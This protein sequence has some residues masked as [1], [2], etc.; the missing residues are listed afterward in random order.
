MTAPV[1]MIRSLTGGGDC[2]TLLRV[3]KSVAWT[4]EETVSVGVGGPSDLLIEGERLCRLIYEAEEWERGSCG[5]PVMGDR[6]T[7]SLMDELRLT[8]GLVDFDEAGDC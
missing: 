6:G 7:S 2:R 1:G 5:R 8:T 4:V 3:A